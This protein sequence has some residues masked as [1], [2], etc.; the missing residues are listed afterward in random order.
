M[1]PPFVGAPR[2]RRFA[3]RAGAVALVVIALDVVATAATLALGYKV[4]RP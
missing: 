2:L 1:I 4:L 3:K